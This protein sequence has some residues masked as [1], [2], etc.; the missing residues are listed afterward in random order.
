MNNEKELMETIKRLQEKVEELSESMEDDLESS[1]EMDE[2]KKRSQ[3]FDLDPERTDSFGDSIEL[4][5]KTR[6]SDYQESFTIARNFVIREY[7]NMEGNFFGK[8][9]KVIPVYNDDGIENRID[10]SWFSG[11]DIK[12]IEI[13]GKAYYKIRLLV[14]DIFTKK[15]LLTRIPTKDG[16]ARQEEIQHIGAGRMGENWLKE[17]API[18]P[19]KPVSYTPPKNNKTTMKQVG[20]IVFE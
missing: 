17:H 13:N 14:R 12:V 5:T 15:L 18:N 1:F 2:P 16:A 11:N 7:Y 6:L 20:E 19:L 3:M 8:H 9:S 10:M 4:I